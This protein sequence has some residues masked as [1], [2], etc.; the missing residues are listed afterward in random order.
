MTNLPA[1]TLSEGASVVCVFCIFLVPLAAGGLALLNAGLARSRGAAHT[2]VASVCILSVAAIAY[3]VCGFAVQGFTGQRSHVLRAGGQ[4]WDWIGAGPFFFRKFELDGSPASL[5]AGLSMLCAGLAA[6]IPLGAAA[7]RW[8]RRF[9]ERSY[10]R[11][12]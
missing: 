7:E 8:P 12:P 6:L 1:A 3:F 4:Q 2:M 5:A 9:L 10:C 11:K